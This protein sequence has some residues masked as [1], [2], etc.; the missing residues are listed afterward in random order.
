MQGAIADLNIITNPKKLL[1]QHTRRRNIVSIRIKKTAMSA[2]RDEIGLHRLSTINFSFLLTGFE[3]I[4]Q[5]KVFCSLSDY[6]GIN[7]IK[8]GLKGSIASFGF[9]IPSRAIVKNW[10]QIDQ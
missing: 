4:L 3:K 9:T 10:S 7:V 1:I 8:L 2:R 5:L 6:L